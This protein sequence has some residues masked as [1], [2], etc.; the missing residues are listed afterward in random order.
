MAERKIFAGARL[1]RLRLKLGIT[2]SQ[3]AAQLGL[4]PSYLNLIE[5][6]QRPLTVQVLLRLSSVYGIGAADLSGV[7]SAAILDRLK[8][9]FADPLLAGEVASTAELAEMAEA[10]PNAALGVARLHQA[11]IEALQRLSDLTH[12]MAQGGEEPRLHSQRAP[13]PTADPRPE[14]GRQ[15]QAEI[16]GAAETVAARLVPRDDPA[17]ALRT[18]LREEFG[19][20]AR[21]LPAHIMPVEQARFDRHSARLFIAERVPLLERP[22]LLARQA[23]LLGH[24]DLLNRLARSAALASPEAERTCR[25]DL[26]RRLA[27]AMLAPAGRLSAALAETGPDVL[28]LSERFVLRPFRIMARIAAVA[29]RDGLPQPFFLLADVSGATLSCTPGAGF[30]FPRFGPLCARL[31][32]FDALQPSQP[33]Y[34]ELV[35]PDDTAFLTVAILDEGTR[36]PPLPPPRRLALLGWPRDKALAPYFPLSAP[37][38]GIGV[39]CRLCERLDCAHRVHPLVSRPVGLQENVVG[40]SDYELS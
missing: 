36:V 12:R 39:T 4:S 29:G 38:R 25:L 24:R 1:R 30:P 34:A 27:E 28:S 9:V 35:L 23:A 6:D 2:Q 22:F 26:A 17:Q 32:I 19:V 3:M 14:T 40:P 8:E 15:I 16:E 31:P 10:A 5:R 37:A 18:H 20:D 13:T 21:I 33:A 11:W 7:E